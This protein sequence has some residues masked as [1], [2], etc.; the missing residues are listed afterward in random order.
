MFCHRRALGRGVGAGALFGEKLILN[1]FVAFTS[2][3]NDYLA[4]M[5]RAH[6]RHRDLL[7]VRIR[8][9]VVDRHPARR[10]R[11]SRA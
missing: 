7:A 4:G 6:A 10:A 3:L 5:S 8:Q 1:E 9:P 2:H 11:C